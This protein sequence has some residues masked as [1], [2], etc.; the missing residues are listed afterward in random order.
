MI[1]S[2]TIEKA[3]YNISYMAASIKV[4]KDAGGKLSRSAFI[5]A[6]SSLMG[7]LP[8]T[9]DGKENRAPYNKTKFD[10]Y[11][12]FIDVDEEGALLLTPR[13]F[14]M[15]EYIREDL[16]EQDPEKRFDF[17]DD[18][19]IQLR[20]LFLS[21]IVFDSFGSY[22]CGAEESNSDIEPPKVILRMLK[23]IGVA[24]KTEIGFVL[25]GLD[26]GALKSWDDAMNQVLA[27]RTDPT[28]DYDVVINSWGRQNFVSDFKML[29]LLSYGKIKLL[30]VEGETYRLAS[31]LSEEQVRNIGGIYPFVR[32]LHFFF[33]RGLHGRDATLAWI[34]SSVLGRVS[35]PGYVYC[36]DAKIDSPDKIEAVLAD[37]IIRALR[38]RRRGV[39]DDAQVA[40]KHRN[41]VVTF[42]ITNVGAKDQLPKYLAMIGAAMK[43][44]DDFQADD[45]GWSEVSAVSSSLFQRIVSDISSAAVFGMNNIVLPANL[46]IMG[47]F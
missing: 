43:R 38:L 4:L 46:N 11:F 21:S 29:D 30:E 42:V 9:P 17:S 32:P 37:A 18:S 5:A 27:N 6:M 12:G 33:E 19:Q 14:R 22:N 24:T 8:I 36:C 15:A 20:E 26:G 35:A 13:G 3:N 23:D 25:W 16:D 44:K 10:R 40:K 28:W 41:A 47:V 1:G 2:L 39:F 45:H 34:R 7:C 31:D